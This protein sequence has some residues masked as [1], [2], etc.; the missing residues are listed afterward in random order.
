MSITIVSSPPKLT[1]ANAA[2]KA[3]NSAAGSEEQGVIL[4]FA[5]LL[6]GQLSPLAQDIL[7]AASALVESAEADAADPDNFLA[8]LGLIQPEQQTRI[9]PSESVDTLLNAAGKIDQ[10][11]ADGS[12][13]LPA[14][15]DTRT[16][17]GMSPTADDKAAK[18]AATASTALSEPALAS[19]ITHDAPPNTLSALNTQAVAN[20]EQ[21]TEL[22][23]SVATP[24][25]DQSWSADF[26][27]KV[28]WLATHDKQMAQITLNPPQMG[29][30]E[31]SLR[32]DKANATASFFSANADVRE[33]IEAALPRLREML[34]SSGIELGQT[35]VSAESFRQA[36][37]N[38]Q[39]YR[40]PSQR[41]E[42][43]V[44]LEP[45]TAGTLPARAFTA[46]QGNSLV[47]IFA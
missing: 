32:M 14:T 29:P 16:S 20:P 1:P 36:A 43:N 8:T 24:V 31:I 21:R 34:A 45:N 2:D 17:L 42:D 46:Q 37:G 30:I 41:S 4:D 23:L 39:G 6:L 10:H 27:Q 26:G 7:P 38:E 18:F 13:L 19:R 12:K 22:A 9:E 40:S 44:I 5:S 3:P 47:D 35:N 25:R 28:V 15:A 33:A 11:A